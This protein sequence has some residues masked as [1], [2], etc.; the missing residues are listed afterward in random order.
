MVA[1]TATKTDCTSSRHRNLSWT[2]HYDSLHTTISASSP[3][4]YFKL[5]HCVN[6]RNGW[7]QNAVIQDNARC[8]PPARQPQNNCQAFTTQLK[9]CNLF[10]TVTTLQSKTPGYHVHAQITQMSTT[11]DAATY[12]SVTLCTG[13]HRTG[14]FEDHCCN[15]QSS[16]PRPSGDIQSLSTVFC[17]LTKLQTVNVRAC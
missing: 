15:P 12:N 10:L 16:S 4:D 2:H 5:H 17:N 3:V 1:A 7:L 9:C 14:Q 6:G 13:A 11:Q 8:F